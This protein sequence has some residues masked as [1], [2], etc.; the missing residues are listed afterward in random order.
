MLPFVS[1]PTEQLKARY[2]VCLQKVWEIPDDMD[3]S[4]P[5]A[6]PDRPGLHREYVFD[7]KCG[8]RLLISRD[9]Y[10]RGPIQLHISA[11][12]EEREPQR[13]AQATDTVRAHFASLGGQG[14]PLLLGIS[15]NGVPH[16][17]VYGAH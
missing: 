10:G 16:W 17:I 9:K 6:M 5:D 2:P 7:F 13:L 14:Y 1:E 11:S 3:L 15:P 4:D 8:L 12:W